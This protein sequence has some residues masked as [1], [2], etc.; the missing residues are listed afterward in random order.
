MVLHASA[1]MP[2]GGRILIETRNTELL[3]HGRAHLYAMLS[4]IYAGEEPDL[5]RI[6]EPSSTDGAGLALSVVYTLV[7][8]HGGHISAQRTDDGS[9]RME[10]LLPAWNNQALAPRTETARAPTILLIDDRDQVRSQ[11][12]NFF[13]AQGYS[14]LEAADST[15]ALAISEVHEGPLDVLI[16][17]EAQAESIAAGIHSAHPRAEFL[18]IVEHEETGPREIRRPF[19]QQTLLDRIQGLFEGSNSSNTAAAG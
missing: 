4:I 17:E 12:H 13:E 8:E 9:C 6:F 3:L 16:A 7:T 19:T 15:E 14:V 1:T 11:L 10:M 18:R 2:K 5:E